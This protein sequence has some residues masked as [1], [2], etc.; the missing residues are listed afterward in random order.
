MDVGE[1]HRSRFWLSVICT[2][3]RNL[4]FLGNIPK[5]TNNKALPPCGW[6]FHFLIVMKV[7]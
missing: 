6:G 3:M 5:N 4:D 2:L 1:S 7:N